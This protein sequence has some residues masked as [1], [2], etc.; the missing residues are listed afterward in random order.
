M[1]KSYKKNYSKSMYDDYNNSHKSVNKK[2]KR[3]NTRDI[4][5][6]YYNRIE[7]EDDYMNYK[8]KGHR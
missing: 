7:D 6:S 2:Q 3:Y 1:G 5:D 8:H 4:L